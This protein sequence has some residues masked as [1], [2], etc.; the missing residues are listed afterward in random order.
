MTDPVEWLGRWVDEADRARLDEAS[1]T[2]TPSRTIGLAGAVI[3]WRAHIAKID[4]DLDKPPDDRSVW[5]AHDLVAAVILRDIVAETARLVDPALLTRIEPAIAE[6]DEWFRRITE[7]DDDGCVERADG[8]RVEGRDWWWHRIPT[9]GPIREE[10]RDDWG[11]GLS[12]G[13]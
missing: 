7:P 10:L 4:A 12:T 5:G 8:R 2:L 6:V 9:R 11:H 13:P 1:V 3:G